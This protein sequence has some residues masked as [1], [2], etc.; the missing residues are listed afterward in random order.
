MA[1]GDLY[2]NT[3]INFYN[4][5]KENYEEFYNNEVVPGCQAFASN[6][7][8]TL[9]SKVNMIKEKLGGLE[10]DWNDSVDGEFRNYMATFVSY[11]QEVETSRIVKK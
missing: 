10:L 7:V 9:Q 3:K 11:L 1:A 5:Y 6:S 2:I 4:D 8:A